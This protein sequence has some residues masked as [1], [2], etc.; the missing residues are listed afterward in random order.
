VLVADD[1]STQ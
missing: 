1:G